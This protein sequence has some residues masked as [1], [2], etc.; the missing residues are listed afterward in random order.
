MGEIAARLA[1]Q[2][3][4]TSDNPRSESPDLILEAILKGVPEGLRS[5]VQSQADRAQAIA[6]AIA[7]A[8]PNDLV[9]IAG[10]GHEQ[11]QVIGTQ[12]FVFSDVEHAQQS[13]HRWQ[14]MTQ[15]VAH[16]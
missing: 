12:A 10:K 15:G 11:R 9:L 6:D 2:V 5:K 8:Q 14:S 4:L 16:A 7:M 1:D 3:V 13:L